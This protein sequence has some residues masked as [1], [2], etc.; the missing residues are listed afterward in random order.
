MGPV[1]SPLLALAIAVLLAAPLRAQCASE[2]PVIGRWDLRVSGAGTDY[3]SWLE[4]TPSGNGFLVGR[5]VGRYGSARP[6]GG[7]SYENGTVRFSIPPQWERGTADLHFDGKLDGDR[8]RGTVT[9]PD[10]SAHA[11][12]GAR[13]PALIHATPG[14]GPTIELFD[15]RDLRGWKVQGSGSHWTVVK[16]VLTSPKAGANLYTD[17]TFTDFKLHLEFRYPGNG[18]SGVYLR[19]RYEV[20]IEDSPR[21]EIPLPIDI[22]GVY[23]FLWPNENAATGPGRWQ[24]F[25]ITLVGRLITVVLNGHTV[26]ADQL[27]PGPTGGTPTGGPLDSDEGAP[28]PILL[29]GDHSAIEYRNI[30]ITVPR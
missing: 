2:P 16:S 15:G 11:F 13:A 25:D 17:R 23:G 6:I 20:Q 3:P 10:G 1:R 19:G 5:F 21:R 26:I 24:T 7:V 18:N 22:G 27:I 9:D 28:G 14:W 4:V 30:R 29:Q 12:S 8:L